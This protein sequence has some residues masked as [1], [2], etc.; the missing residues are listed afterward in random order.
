MTVT[1]LPEL[2]AIAFMIGLGS[3]G[4]CLLMCG[5]ISSALSSQLA[6]ESPALKISKLLLF[7]FGRI[8]CYSVLGLL[9]GSTIHWLLSF[10]GNL[11][12]IARIISALL[13]IL[14]GLYVAGIPTIIKILEKQLGFIWQRLQPVTR[15]YIHM[16]QWH[17]AYILGFLWGFLPCGMIYSTLLWASSNNQGMLTAL[18]MFSFGLGTLPA[19]FITNLFSIKTMAFFQQ[20][21]YKRAIGILLIAFG[22]WSLG[23]MAMPHGNHE[24]HDM[25]HEQPANNSID[26]APMD[27]HSHHHHHVMPDKN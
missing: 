6:D 22:L 11:V 4:H 26:T 21:H 3:T 18:L 20:K 7:H 2:L 17:H 25:P 9:L 1:N 13:I 10:S 15:R 14:M 19:L 8:S 23:F 5:G 27:G 24:Q 16:Q 12:I